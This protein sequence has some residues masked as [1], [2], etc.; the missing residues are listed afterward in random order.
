[1]KREP[2]YRTG[3]QIHEGDVVRIGAWDGMVESIITSESSGWAD[4]WSEHG[5]GV[6]LT[7][8]SFG[9]LYTKFHNEDLVLVRRKQ[10]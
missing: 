6:M 5:E 9:R 3:E 2:T 7:G 1:M 8:P 10:A 4:Y